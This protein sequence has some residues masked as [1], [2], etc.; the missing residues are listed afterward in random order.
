MKKQLYSLLDLIDYYQE[1]A[2]KSSGSN[3]VIY[4]ATLQALYKL[5][6]ITYSEK[7]KK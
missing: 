5:K 7:Y 1:K 6:K 2:S 3:Y 4:N